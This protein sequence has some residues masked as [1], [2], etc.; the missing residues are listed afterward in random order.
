MKKRIAKIF[1]VCTV[2]LSSF[3]LIAATTLEDSYF[4][5][6]KNLDVF[7]TLF[8]EVNMYYVDETKPGDLIKKGIDAML[9][10]LDPYTNYIPESDIEDYRFMTTG[11]YGGVGATIKKQGDY[12][13]IAEPYE[14]F[15]AFKA[16]LRAGDII[17][18]IDGKQTKG[19]NTEDISK[20]LKGQPSTTVKLLIQREEEKKP[21]EK[22]IVREEIKINSVPYYGMLNDKIGYIYLSQ[23]TES[24]SRE[25]KEALI[26]L[27]ENKKLEGV[28]FDLRGNPGG[29][30]NEA[31]NISNLF[32]DKGQEIVSTK[33]KVKEWEKVYKALNVPVDL[34]IPVAVLV[35]SG[36]ASASEIVSGTIQDLDRG[37]I[38]GQR[39]Y[40]KG[41]VQTTRNLSYNSKLKVTT[42]K[43]Y[44]PSGRCIQALDYAN[45][46]EDGSVG[47][48][49]DSLMKPF[50]TK[51][52]RR[53]L[54]GGGVLPDVKTKPKQY[55]KITQSLISKNLIFDF[56]TKYRIKNEKIGEAMTFRLTDSEYNDFVT[57]IADKEYDY[58]TK[59]EKLAKDLKEAAESEKY[60]EKI[61]DEYDA[62]QKKVAHNKQEDVMTF[63]KEI[64]ELLEG[65]IVARYYYQKGRIQNNLDKDPDVKTA[66]E[67]LTEQPKYSAILKGTYK[68][69]ENKN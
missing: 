17:L 55:S 57:F 38:V 45:R 63:K 31:V 56:A 2:A 37:V 30:L 19:K 25:V 60:F 64:K 6:S 52:G 65:E 16:G 20:L 8:R 33:G 49:P 47:K 29:L 36:S 22:S 7:G 34:D 10:S 28:V 5:I 67:L 42:A 66:I 12:I 68:D 27:K 11:Q 1:V 24:A 13:A 54:D 48:M 44:I 53:V 32:V 4:E 43:Y 35:N 41:L 39:T 61:K 3:M 51:N 9:E 69:E 59:S 21:F 23:F 40:G 46:N 62:L 58:T 18:E 26:A 15:P 50:K 14:N